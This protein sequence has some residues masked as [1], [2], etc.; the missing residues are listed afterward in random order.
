[1]KQPNLSTVVFTINLLH[2]SKIIFPK[3]EMY[4]EDL[5]DS[6]PLKTHFV[7]LVIAE[8]NYRGVS[9]VRE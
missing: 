4:L 2:H 9:S 5:P 8:I 6:L 1:M 3:Y 7:F